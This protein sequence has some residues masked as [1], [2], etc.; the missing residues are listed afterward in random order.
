M[1]WKPGLV[2]VKGEVVF[3]GA[4][5]LQVVPTSGPDAEGYDRHLTICT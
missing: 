1:T 2:T 3:P 5:C 4:L